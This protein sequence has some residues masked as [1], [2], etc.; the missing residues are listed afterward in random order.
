MGTIPNSFLEQ[1]I[2]NRRYRNQDHRPFARMPPT[3]KLFQ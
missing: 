3:K 2:V 1:Q